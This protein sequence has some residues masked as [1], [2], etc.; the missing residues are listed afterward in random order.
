MCHDARGTRQHLAPWRGSESHAEGLERLRSKKL[1]RFQQPL[2]EPL[3]VVI[4]QERFQHVAVGRRTRRPPPP[5]PP[6][7]ARPSQPPP[8]PPPRAAG[9]PAR[10]A[11]PR[12][13]PRA[14]GGRRG[15]PARP[16][17]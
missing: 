9:A 2:R 4:A 6:P 12:R 3:L 10:R 16:R 7:P 8:P 13:P 5:P 14:R 11:P 15:P 17:T 1:F